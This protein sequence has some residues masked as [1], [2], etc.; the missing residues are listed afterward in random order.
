M[1][2]LTLLKFDKWL[3]DQLEYPAYN[4][5]YKDF[6][7]SNFSS[8]ST[9]NILITLKSKKKIKKSL[10]KKKNFKFIEKNITFAKFPDKD[11]NLDLKNIRFAKYKDKKFVLDIAENTLS[12]SRFYTDKKIK[13]KLAK[14]I[15]RNWILNFFKKKRA[16]YLIVATWKKKGA[17]FL[18]II[19]S[20]KNYIVDLIYVYKDYQG[21]GLG[22]KMIKFCENFVVKDN[23]SLIYVST[24]VENKKFYIRNRFIIKEIKYVYHQNGS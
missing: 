16:D 24:Q 3:S 22:S 20:K 18:S 7:L 9:K 5:K 19:K 15:K 21:L 11:L 4:I 23:K 2:K 12:K 13:K 10:L 8:P 6:K 1:K 14:K 17:G